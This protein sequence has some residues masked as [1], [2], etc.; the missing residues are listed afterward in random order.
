MNYTWGLA[1]YR[2]HVRHQLVES[3]DDFVLEK[4][5]KGNTR[6]PIPCCRGTLSGIRHDAAAHLVPT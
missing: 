1:R 2:M 6:A 4:S 5:D 3:V